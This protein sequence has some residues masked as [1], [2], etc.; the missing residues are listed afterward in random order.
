MEATQ[1][2]HPRT[3]WIKVAYPI[4]AF[5][6]AACVLGQVFLAGLAIF[7]RPAYWIQHTTFVHIFEAIPILILILLL[8]GKAPRDRGLYWPQFVILGLI[9]VQ[10]LTAGDSMGMGTVAGAVHPV[11]AMVLFWV[12]TV[13]IRR[14][15]AWQR[16]SDQSAAQRPMPARAQRQ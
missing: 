8:I 4:L 7:Y 12:S 14:G 16:D 9:M 13:A 10:Y 5:V 2:L 6:F 11:S 3:R 15:F 1:N